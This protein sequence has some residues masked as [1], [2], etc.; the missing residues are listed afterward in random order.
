MGSNEMSN[1][2]HEIEKKVR[3]NVR[4]IDGDVTQD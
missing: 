3:G 2:H 1:V 4:E